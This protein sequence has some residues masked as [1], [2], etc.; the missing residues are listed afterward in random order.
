MYEQIKD[1]KCTLQATNLELQTELSQLQQEN[2]EFVAQIKNINDQIEVE[3]ST[4]KD[5]LL[6]LDTV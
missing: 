3:Q 1:E 2:E 4:N 5:L 6:S